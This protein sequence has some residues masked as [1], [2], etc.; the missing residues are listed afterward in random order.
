LGLEKPDKPLEKCE[1]KYINYTTTCEDV[2][3]E[4]LFDYVPTCSYCVQYYNMT[5]PT[6]TDPCENTT[7]Y[8]N[9]FGDKVFD[10]NCTDPIYQEKVDNIIHPTAPP[11]LRI[12][13]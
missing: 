12:I 13:F 1:K 5:E 2:F 6:C 10:M 11:A 7:S 9:E 3:N 4:T 8:I